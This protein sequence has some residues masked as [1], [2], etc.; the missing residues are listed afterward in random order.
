MLAISSNNVCST[1]VSIKTV[2]QILVH[3]E[4]SRIQL[5]Q[6]RYTLLLPDHVSLQDDCSMHLLLQ[7]L[8]AIIKWSRPFSI[9]GQIRGVQRHRQGSID[10]GCTAG[11]A[12]EHGAALGAVLRQ[13]TAATVWLG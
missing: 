2:P 4:V 7:P 10:A 3:Q 9:Q 5:R 13:L 1:F 11:V 6:S 12:Q 8:H